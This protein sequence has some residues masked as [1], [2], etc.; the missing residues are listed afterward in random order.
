MYIF[1]CSVKQAQSKDHNLSLKDFKS[2]YIKCGYSKET[3]RKYMGK[4]IELGWANRSH[5]DGSIYLISYKRIAK[6]Y[7]INLRRP[8]R[9]YG[10][11]QKELLARAAC[12]YL[13]VNTKAQAVKVYKVKKAKA[14]KIAQSYDNTGNLGVSVRYTAKLVG[15]SS[16]KSGSNCFNEMVRLGMV[17][18]KNRVESICHVSEFNEYLAKEYNG[19]VFI[20]KRDNMVKQRLKS[21][22]KFS[23]N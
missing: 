19:R 1:L 18:R 16:A 14:V 17:E 10:K 21:L 20:D 5:K 13:E 15:Y 11:S 8:K 23:K 22:T 6:E 9:V 7:G 3:V 4:L 12:I 2:A